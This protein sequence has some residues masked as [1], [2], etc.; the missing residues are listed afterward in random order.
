MSQILYYNVCI[1]KNCTA[2]AHIADGACRQ[3]VLEVELD[4][5]FK[6]SEVVVFFRVKEKW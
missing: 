4:M 3:W 5:I 2:A 1:G 6:G